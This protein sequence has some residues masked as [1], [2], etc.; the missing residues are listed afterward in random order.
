M[1]KGY[2]K[3]LDINKDKPVV[4]V[5]F[6]LQEGGTEKGILFPESYN[7]NENGNL[8]QHFTRRISEVG[9]LFDFDNMLALLKE[10][11]GNATFNLLVSGMGTAT[12]Q[13][14]SYDKL[15]FHLYTN[16]KKAADKDFIKDPRWSD[17]SEYGRGFSADHKP[18]SWYDKCFKLST[19]P[20]QQK[21]WDYQTSTYITRNKEECI[22]EYN[23]LL[24]RL[25]EILSTMTG[26]GGQKINVQF[27]FT[28]EEANKYFGTNTEIAESNV[29]AA[30]KP[31]SIDRKKI[32][33]SGGTDTNIRLRLAQAKIKIAKAK[34]AI[35]EAAY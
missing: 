9:K 25:F 35:A 13:V 24:N 8:K 30:W 11:G 26:K 23:K 22:E 12:L 1:L 14:T 2:S 6:T 29:D 27:D 20:I 21:T 32:P 5:N 19:Y 10:K 17:L 33:H 3:A 31:L 28:P 7:P 18:S 4:L 15:Q 34:I 16:N